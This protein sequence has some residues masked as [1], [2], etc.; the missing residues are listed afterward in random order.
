MYYT[1][2]YCGES[3]SYKRGAKYTLDIVDAP[4]SDILLWGYRLRVYRVTKNRRY[5]VWSYKN[6]I[7][8]FQ[9]WELL[10]KVDGR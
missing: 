9:D 10:G 2:R 8:F 7:S 3:T 5:F 4:L 6:L 1:C